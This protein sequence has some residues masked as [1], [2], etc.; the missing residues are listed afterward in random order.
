MTS[1]T[2][3]LWLRWALSLSLSLTLTLTLPLPLTLTLTLT[4]S[5]TLTP[6]QAPAGDTAGEIIPLDNIAS[7]SSNASR[8]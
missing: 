4:L 5:L 7:Q 6:K 1:F 2:A 8:I 3:G